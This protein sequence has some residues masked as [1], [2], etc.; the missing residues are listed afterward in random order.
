MFVD[1]VTAIYGTDLKLKDLDLDALVFGTQKALAL[2]PGLAFI[3]C[4]DRLLEKARTVP[5]E[6]TTST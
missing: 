5:N 6:A 4:S 1:G 2:P 3:C